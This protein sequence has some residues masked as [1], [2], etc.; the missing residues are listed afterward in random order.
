MLLTPHFS[1]AELIRSQTAIR[2][3]IDNTP[4]KTVTDNLQDLCEK[5]LEP[6]RDHF[7]QPVIVTSGYRSPALN[8]RIGGSGTSQHCFGMAADFTVANVSNWDVCQYA[9]KNLN[10]DQLIFE[11]GEA[12][13]IH[14]SYRE[15][16]NRNMELSA[17]KV[18]GKTKYLTGLI[19]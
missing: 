2:R 13:W 19:R 17:K 4:D 7:K 14:I 6:I 9:L 1:L 18:S 15:G 10:Y 12:G 3:N 11:Y 8:K 16:D 5:V